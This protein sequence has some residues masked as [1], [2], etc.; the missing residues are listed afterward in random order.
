MNKAI[1][2]VII[3]IGI[4][5]LVLTVLGSNDS[6]EKIEVESDKVILEE[7]IVIEESIVSEEEEKKGRDISIEFTESLGIAGP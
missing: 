2:G 4:G 6:T 7:S 1:V 5:V 3:A